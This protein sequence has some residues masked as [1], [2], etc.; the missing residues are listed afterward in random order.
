MSTDTSTTRPPLGLRTSD[1]VTAA[2]TGLLTLPDPARRTPATRF[3][4]RTAVAGTTGAG[5]WLGTDGE[6]ALDLP[7]RFAFTAGAVGFVYGAAELGEAVDRALQR[8]LVRM[9]VRRPRLTMALAGVGASL[10]ISLLERRAEAGEEEDAPEGPVLRPLPE[11]VREL[12]SA[13]L[14]HT[15]DYDSLRLRAQ[16]TGARE[17]V[18]GEPEDAP[19]LVELSVP[20]NAPLAVPHSFTFPVSARFTSARAVPCAA[21]V[22]VSGGRLAA[23]VVDLDEDAWEVLAE[24]WD[25]AG[26][27]PDPLADVTLPRAQDVILVTEARG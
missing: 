26:G 4:L 3:V 25:A 22:L 11:P 1:L 16:L 17:E 21:R 18:W 9:G 27:D 7:G 10:A 6:P 8:R 19:R 12:V 13:I 14:S 24:D 2:A 15:E 5:V 20:E 23:V